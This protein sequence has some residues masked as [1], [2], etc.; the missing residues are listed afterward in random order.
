MSLLCGDIGEAGN[1]ADASEKAQARAVETVDAES[2]KENDEMIL[3]R[4]THILFDA[5]VL[6]V[7]VGVFV[8]Y[9]WVLLWLVCGGV[10]CSLE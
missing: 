2:R 4:L 1:G 6:A 5:L 8:V 10:A 7:T 9:A 3:T